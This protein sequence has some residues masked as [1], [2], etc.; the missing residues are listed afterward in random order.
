MHYVGI[1]LH[2]KRS[3]YVV[4]D[5]DG[6]VSRKRTIPSTPQAF[7]EGFSSLDHQHT[8]VTR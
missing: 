3:R 1:D 2:K 5:Q 6:Q 7:Q 8:R 4:V